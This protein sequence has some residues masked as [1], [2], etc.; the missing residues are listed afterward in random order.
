MANQACARCR[1]SKPENQERNGS[2]CAAFNAL[3]NLYNPDPKTQAF[4]RFI[5]L[6]FLTARRHLGKHKLKVIARFFQALA[7]QE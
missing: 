5:H 3:A 7:S 4:K 1:F 6:L 2:D